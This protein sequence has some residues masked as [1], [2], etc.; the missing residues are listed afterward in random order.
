MKLPAVAIATA[1]ALGIVCGPGLEIRHRSS[2]GFV[3]FPPGS[4]ATSLLISFV[5]AWRSRVVVAAVA[6][7][8]RIAG[9]D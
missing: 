9:G 5:F 3:P 6:S 1:F 4:A 2:H 7:R 8:C